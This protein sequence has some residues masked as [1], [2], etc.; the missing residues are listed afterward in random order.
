M[1][2]GFG[3]SPLVRG[4]WNVMLPVLAMALAMLVLTLVYRVAR[5]RS[6]TWRSVL[7]GIPAWCLAAGALCVLC[8]SLARQPPTSRLQ[9]AGLYLFLPRWST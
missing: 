1:I 3:K 8:R 2:G 5:G 7:P 4:F 9:Y 6:T